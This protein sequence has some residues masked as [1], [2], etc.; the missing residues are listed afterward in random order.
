M[1][2]AL[3]LIIGLGNPGPKYTQTRHNAGFWFVDRLAS[4][5]H[6]DFRSEARM[7]AESADL[8]ADGIA[9]RLV[10]PTTFM[11]ESGRAVRAY[12][13]YYGIEAESILVVYDEVDFPPGTVRLKQGGGD[14][15][16][17]GLG[18]VI[19]CLDSREFLRLRIGVGHPGRS[20]LVRDYVL[21]R[22]AA[23]ERSAIDAAMERAHAVMPLLF[24]G[25]VHKAMSTLNAHSDEAGGE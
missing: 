21:N 4:D 19:A 23:E 1:P 20:D 22:P 17:N 16:H 6:A 14:A 11:N 8:R 3:R 2:S 12:T 18:D 7:H 5:H 13:D 15:G 25:E 10:K 9:C 24:A